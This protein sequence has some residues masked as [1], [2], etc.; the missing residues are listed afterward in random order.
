MLNKSLASHHPIGTMECDI[1]M[2]E[3]DKI[4]L[5]CFDVNSSRSIH[6]ERSGGWF[7]S[8]TNHKKSYLNITKTYPLISK[9]ACLFKPSLRFIITSSKWF[10]REISPMW[11]HPAILNSYDKIIISTLIFLGELLLKKF[12]KPDLYH[13]LCIAAILNLSNF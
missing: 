8:E 13:L 1:Q 9:D 12:C 6:G 3:S 11:C 2:R 5:F 10:W 7:K 4:S